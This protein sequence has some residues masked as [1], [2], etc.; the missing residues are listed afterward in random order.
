VSQAALRTWSRWILV[1]FACLAG[2]YAGIALALVLIQLADRLCPP[3]LVVSGM[4]GA[5]WYPA[6]ERAALCAGAALGGA[7]AVL[8]PRQAA[9]AARPRVATAA[10][11]CGAAYATW[12]LASVGSDI[13]A[14]WAAA[15]AGGALAL[16]HAYRARAGAGPPPRRDITA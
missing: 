11:V 16:A 14:P 7:L 2:V 8:L 6:A 9:P 1:P 5:P 4:C 13:L 3:E 10:F 12:F 15:L